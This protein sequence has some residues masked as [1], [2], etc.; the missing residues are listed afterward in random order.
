MSRPTQTGDS[1]RISTYFYMLM[2]RIDKP[3]IHLITD[4]QG[5]MLDAEVSND[6]QLLSGIHL[7]IL[8]ERA[9]PVILHVRKQGLPACV[10]KEARLPCQWGYVEYL[11]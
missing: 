4:A 8:K 5:V 2:S 10:S 9:Q 11:I 3:L 7:H 1:V 6:L